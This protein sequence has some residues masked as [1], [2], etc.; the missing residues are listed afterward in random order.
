[1]KREEGEGGGDPAFQNEGEMVFPNDEEATRPERKT[2]SPLA[3]LFLLLLPLLLSGCGPV[4]I[5]GAIIL[6]VTLSDDDGDGCSIAGDMVN[7]TLR[8]TVRYQN[9]PEDPRTGPPVLTPVRGAR[10][11]IL[12]INCGEEVI[13]AVET[14]DDGTYQASADTPSGSTL[15]VS[16]LSQRVASGS[17]V[18]VRNNPTERLVYSLESADISLNTDAVQAQTIDLDILMDCQVQLAGAFNLL[19]E[20]VRDF[21]AI[22]G[23]L[24]PSAPPLTILWELGDPD[25]TFFSVSGSDLTGDGLGGDPFIQIRGG[26]FLAGCFNTD[27]F[28]DSLIAHEF[29]HYIA[30]SYSRDDSPGGPHGVAELLDPR[31]AWSEGW[32][33]FFSGMARSNPEFIDS[34]EDVLGCSGLCNIFSFSIETKSASCLPLSCC[35][36]IG[37]EEAVGALLWDLFDS[38]N[39]G[40]DV[41]QIPAADMLAAL[42][43][44]QTHRFVY[45]GDYIEEIRAQVPGQQAAID[46]LVLRED[47]ESDPGT[48]VPFPS[49]FPSLTVSGNSLDASAMGEVNGCDNLPCKQHV[50]NYIESSDFYEVQIPG[51]PGQPGTFRAD[52]TISGGPF[53]FCEREVQLRVYNEAQTFLYTTEG[54]TGLAKSLVFSFDA[55]FSRGSFFLVEVAGDVATLATGRG[56]KGDYD[57]VIDVQ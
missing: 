34:F 56:Q 1:M 26:A 42:S 52:L 6:A 33:D 50:E 10:V 27:P 51:S 38:I 32:A 31:L 55:E 53:A 23:I 3:P 19:D 35:E 13:A 24:P 21:E 28:D 20:A 7:V 11:E 37:S 54:Q 48:V 46:A 25:G 39:D 36:G 47:M 43:E 9:R 12:R 57:V 30:F 44:L 5:V 2:V 41:A 45:V 29:G 15:R 14:A 22:A 18:T 40:G 16:V 49:D 4:L 17:T 8:G